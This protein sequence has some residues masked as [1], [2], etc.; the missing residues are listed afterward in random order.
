MGLQGGG[1]QGGCRVVQGAGRGLQGG[2]LGGAGWGGCRGVQVGRG[3]ADWR[4][5][6]WGDAGW[7]GCRLSCNADNI[8]VLYQDVEICVFPTPV[9]LEALDQSPT[10]PTPVALEA[11]FWERTSPVF[12]ISEGTGCFRC[13]CF[14]R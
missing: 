4:D 6:G 10:L 9:A 3:G 1:V 13:C 14:R 8:D 12:P 11:L 2:L 5:A 7:G